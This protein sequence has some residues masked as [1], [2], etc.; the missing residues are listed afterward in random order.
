MNILALETA[1]DPGSAALWLDGKVRQAICPD[2]LSNS[3]TLLP[4]AMLLLEKAGLDFSALDAIAF[5]AGPGSFTGLRVSC[6][7]AQG[8]AIARGLP[9]IAVGTLEAMAFSSGFEKVIAIQD[10]RMNEVYCGFFINGIQEGE[11]HVSPPEE[12]PLPDSGSWAAIGNALDVYPELHERLDPFVEKWDEKCM[13]SAEAV[14]RLAAVK[15][16]KGECLDPANALPL[17]VRN[18]V[19][20]TIEERMA[21]GGRA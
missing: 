9:L 17:Y 13:P 20:K 6:A 5:G 21:E 11:L 15:F 3:E 4:E 8:I 1:T 16:A 12:M 10:A 18:K 7:L 14:V 19:A 2:A